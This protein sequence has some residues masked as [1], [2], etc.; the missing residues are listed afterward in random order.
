[1]TFGDSYVP[2]AFE[3]MASLAA[4]EAVDML[5]VTSVEA[6][7]PDQRTLQS[8]LRDPDVYLVDM[9]AEHVR[10]GNPHVEAGAN[11]IYWFVAGWEPLPEEAS[12]P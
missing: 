7:V 10:R 4:E 12:V 2:E 1:M 3:L 11:D 6:T 5:G 8:V 9:S